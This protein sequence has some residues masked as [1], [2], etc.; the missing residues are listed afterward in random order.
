MRRAIAGA[1]RRWPG[2]QER[3]L[4]AALARDA[5]FGTVHSDD[6]S[7]FRSILGAASV[8]TDPD[9]VAPHNEDWMRKYRGSS[10]VVLKPR[11]SEQVSQLLAYCSLKRLAVVPQVR[12]AGGALRAARCPAC[13]RPLGQRP[14]RPPASPRRAATP[15]WWAAACPCLTRSCSA[16]QP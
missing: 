1:L 10:K 8:V 14:T 7:F 9:A 15:G 2:R 12:R 6:V 16:P 11:S 3:Q 5:S 4:H 13:A